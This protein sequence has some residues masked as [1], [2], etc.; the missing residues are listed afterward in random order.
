MK[1]S[2]FRCFNLNDTHVCFVL[3]RRRSTA[4]SSGSSVTSFIITNPIFSLNL[5]EILC[6]LRSVI[7][8]NKCTNVYIYIYTCSVWTP[9]TFLYSHVC[10]AFI[11]NITSA[12]SARF[13]ILFHL[14]ITVFF[15]FLSFPLNQINIYNHNKC[16]FS[17]GIHWQLSYYLSFSIRNC[18]GDAFMIYWL[19]LFNSGR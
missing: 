7:T 15:T 5:N 8:A 19:N 6:L 1:Q 4:T 17:A 12:L 9:S 11:T 13:Y 18:F 10:A 2:V 14:L 3:R 16:N